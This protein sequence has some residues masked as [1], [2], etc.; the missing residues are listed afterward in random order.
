MDLDQHL[1]R[2]GV[3][4]DRER[5]AEKDRF[6][7]LPLPERIRKGLGL[8]D[9]EAVEEA[10][11]AGRSLVTY[12]RPGGRELGAPQIGVGSIVRVLPRRDPSD[13]APAGIVARRQ[14][15]S[16]GIVF[17]EPPPDW[18]TQGRVL[19]ELLPSS[20][21]HDRLSGAVRRMREARRWHPVLRGEAPR[22]EGREAVD[23][24][25]VLNSEQL[26]ALEVADRA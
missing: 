6:A 10:G 17:D 5:A 22:F 23:V 1:D 9:V 24:T 26:F 19:I 3:L 14:R 4:L 16:L 25:H 21:T 7:R 11:L 2:L 20:A 8:D 12:A 15:A 13:D 18:A